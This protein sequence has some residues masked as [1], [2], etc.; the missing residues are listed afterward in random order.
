MT[1]AVPVDQWDFRLT[2]LQREKSEDI[3]GTEDV[4]EMENERRPENEK[5][6]V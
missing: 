4:K 3:D 2:E 5:E 1:Q 6:E